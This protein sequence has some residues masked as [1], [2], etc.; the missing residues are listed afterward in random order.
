M[1]T[2]AEQLAQAAE[3]P[4]LIGIF[5]NVMLYGAMITQTFFYFST[6][7]TDPAWI[8]AYVFI[9]FLADT[10]NAV[11]NIAWIYGV[12]ITNFG[13]LSFFVDTAISPETLVALF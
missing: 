12:L 8:K 7:K 4:A 5:L 13:A 10:L 3:G 9:L 11:F 1:S 2:S 6:Y